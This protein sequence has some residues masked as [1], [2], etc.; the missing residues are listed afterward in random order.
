M[1]INH[2]PAETFE[3]SMRALDW[4]EAHPDRHVKR[5]YATDIVGRSCNPESPRAF[6]FC[7]LGRI[8]REAGIPNRDHVGVYLKEIDVEAVDISAMNDHGIP[9]PQIR[10]YITRQY[11][12]MA[13]RQGV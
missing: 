4:L 11:T 9:I 3:V 13:K 12:E 7:A 1:N 8:T 2:T 5:R 6:C 10:D